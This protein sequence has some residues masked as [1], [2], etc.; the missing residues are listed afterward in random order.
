MYKH[1]K[2]VAKKE[3][4]VGRAHHTSTRIRLTTLFVEDSDILLL[5][6]ILTVRVKE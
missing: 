5:R 6:V 2:Y 4:K 1:P 3:L